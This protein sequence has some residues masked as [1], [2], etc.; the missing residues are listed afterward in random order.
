[1]STCGRCR[2]F[3]DDAALIERT[4]VGLTILSSACGDTWGDQ[5]LCAIHDQMLAPDMGCAQFAQREEREPA[6]TR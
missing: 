6:P 4:L 2:H 5:G 3:L 1:M